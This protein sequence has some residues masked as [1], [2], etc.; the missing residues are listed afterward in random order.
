ML[1]FYT[2]CNVITGGGERGMEG[3]KLEVI[4]IRVSTKEKDLIRQLSET[5]E[6]N[7]SDFLRYCILK[8]ISQKESE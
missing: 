7:V 4:Q 2:I 6:M 1:I 5:K 8:E 3:R